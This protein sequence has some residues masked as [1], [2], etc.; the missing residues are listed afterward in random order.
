M[1]P[2]VSPRFLEAETREE[3]VPPVKTAVSVDGTGHNLNLSILR[4]RVVWGME[5]AAG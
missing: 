5:L 4:S 1:A 2:L 3:L